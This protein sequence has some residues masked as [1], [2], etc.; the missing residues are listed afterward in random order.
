MTGAERIAR[1]R[2]GITALFALTSALGLIGLA[3]FA[4]SVDDAAWRTE[5]DKSS[6][7]LTAQGMGLLTYSGGVLDTKDLASAT[8]D[9]CPALTVLSAAQSPP[10]VLH[11]PPKSCPSGHPDEIRALAVTALGNQDVAITDT[12]GV[13]GHAIRLYAR[14][15]VAPS[16]D[17]PGGVLV[18]ATDVAADLA[19][20]RRLTWFVVGGCTLLVALS[21]VIAHLLSGRATRPALTALDQQETFLADAAHDLRTPAASLRAL[22][23]TAR[24]PGGTVALTGEAA[25][26]VVRLATR[27]GN[28]VDGLLTRARLMAGVG[29]VT[30]EPFRL[31]QLA[32]AVVAELPAAGH[33][34]RVHAEP[35]VV[36]GDADLLHRALANL[37]GNALTHG[38]A[39]DTPAEVDL[40]VDA[41][42]RITVDD[43]GPGLPP[44]VADRLFERFH[45]GS[46][47]TGLGLSI[48]SWVAKSHGGTLT[49]G[50]G[51]RGGAR[52]VLTVPVQR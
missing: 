8:D 41:D 44:G 4:I 2:R 38:H 30:R 20:H 45:S 21:A 9:D 31:D 33:A 29:A 10:T 48:A 46:G 34:V 12:T 49:A 37:V 24:G 35:V 43:A 15:F 3:A 7:A 51:P 39:P 36:T 23:E 47:S 22:A 28:L 5:V 6:G 27:M 52:F 17:L 42:G 25:D 19:A 16:A 50:P 13:D 11:T 14:P 32:E 18:T 26:R 40:T 1:L